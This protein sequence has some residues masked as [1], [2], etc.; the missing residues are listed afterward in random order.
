M[1]S[2]RRF[3]TGRADARN[4]VRLYDLRGDELR[5]VMVEFGVTAD[6]RS[7][8]I[9]STSRVSARGRVA[10]TR[11]PGRCSTPFS[12]MAERGSSSIRSPSDSRK[13]GTTS[14]PGDF[15]RMASETCRICIRERSLDRPDTLRR[16]GL[17]S[18]TVG[19]QNDPRNSAR[20]LRCP[21]ELPRLAHLQTCSWSPG[22]RESP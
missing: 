16:T 9:R 3:G 8:L 6:Q 4:G 10:T 11:V 15:N 17:P 21:L 14:I 22:R 20:I 2:I 1:N 19:S 12:G 13:W 7:R 5:I 18:R